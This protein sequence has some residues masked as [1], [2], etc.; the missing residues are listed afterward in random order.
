MIH[1]CWMDDDVYNDFIDD[2][3]FDCSDRVAGTI[4]SE[5]GQL[6]ALTYLELGTFCRFFN[7]LSF[8]CNS[9]HHS[10]LTP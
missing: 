8:H 5:I 7:R 6:T 9:T 2:D 10:R 3:F 4:P 1:G